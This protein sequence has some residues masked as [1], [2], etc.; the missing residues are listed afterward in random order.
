[1]IK[2]SALILFGLLL[3]SS[4]QSQ[5]S[6]LDVDI[7]ANEY[8]VDTS[9]YH[10]IDFTYRNNTDS[11]YIL[12]I[13]KD[14]ADSLLFQDVIRNYF[15]R[16]KGDASLMQIIW[17]GNVASFTPGLFQTFLKIIRPEQQ[18]TVT[19]LETENSIVDTIMLTHL[20]DHIFIANVN[21]IKG[22]PVDS[23]LL[24]MFDHKSNSI[25]ILSKWIEE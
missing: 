12:W 17:D 13:E 1:M 4:L 7:T 15:F 8:Y 21:E 19:V 23:I 18:F 14:A 16:V 25:I 5:L 24:E 22:F 9:E 10:Q 2:T 20:E 6:N 3:C 11:T